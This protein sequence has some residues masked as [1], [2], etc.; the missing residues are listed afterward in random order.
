[1]SRARALWRL[2][3]GAL[4]LVTAAAACAGQSCDTTPPDTYAV[5]RALA[6]A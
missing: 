2:L 1:M 4:A 6:L 5:T 3:V